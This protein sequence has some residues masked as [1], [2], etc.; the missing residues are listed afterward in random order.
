MDRSVVNIR[1]YPEFWAGELIF[2]E[3]GLSLS[4]GTV[5]ELIPGFKE[6]MQQDWINIHTHKPGMGINIVDPC[7]GG[8][9]QLAQGMIYYSMGIHPI[10]ISEDAG[11]RLKEIERA[12]ADRRIVAIGEAGLDRNSAAPMELQMEW[13]RL[14]AEIA[15]RYGLPLIIHGVRAIPELI[16]VYRE[17]SL[18]QGWIMHGFNNRREIL[19][20]L[21]RH[22]FY[23]SVG[24]H[25]MNEESNVYR[26][27]PEIPADRLFVETDN[28][29]YLIE[30]VYRTVAARRNI[31]VRE[32]QETV[33]VN[34]DKLFKL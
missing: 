12:A 20:D 23:I 21:L 4:I 11:L 28:S 7:L 2:R 9:R 33:R 16:S 27:L 8:I 14:Q 15:A 22:D 31:A 5:S 1:D 13:F 25:V 30:E 18:H 34:F 24:R 29:D 26:L 17:C 10:Y 6:I 3:D 32:L 19:Q